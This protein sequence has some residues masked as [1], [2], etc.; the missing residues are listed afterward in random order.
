MDVHVRV[1]ACVRFD[2]L[3]CDL[4]LAKYM[5]VNVF[6]AVCVW[7]DVFGCDVA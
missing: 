3:A 6:V 5:Y 1:V 7:I 4:V 2:V